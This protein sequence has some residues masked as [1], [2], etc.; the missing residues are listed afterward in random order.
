M[1]ET[2]TPVVHGGRPS[3][4]WFSVAL[5]TLGATLVAALIGL[6]L[7]VIGAL[8]GAPWGRAG[9]VVVAAVALVYAAR[10]G[11]RIPIPL[12]DRRAQV[13][14]WWRTFYSPGVAAFLYGA[15]LGAGFLTFLSFGT[16]VAVATGA[17]ASGSPVIGAA[18]CIPFGLVRGLSITVSRSA[19]SE[20]EAES[21]MNRLEELGATQGP[22][23]VNAGMLLIVAVVA[24][25]ATG[26]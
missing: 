5:H 14:D 20:Q 19:R 9:L 1:V 17:L 15:G 25:G 21:I 3:R 11:F 2:I 10:E 8:A 13:P 24:L 18:L 16:Y 6:A 4:Y 22:R 12:P 7:G 23:L 26:L